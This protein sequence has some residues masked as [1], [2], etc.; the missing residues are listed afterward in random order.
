[1]AKRDLQLLILQ[2]AGAV[3]HPP[4]PYQPTT[5]RYLIR[6]SQIQ[7]TLIR[8][9]RPTACQRLMP[10]SGEPTP[11]CTSQGVDHHSQPQAIYL[12]VWSHAVWW[13]RQHGEVQIIC[14]NKHKA[15]NSVDT[16]RNHATTQDYV[17]LRHALTCGRKTLLPSC[18]KKL[19]SMSEFW[20]C[21]QNMCPH[22]TRYRPQQNRTTLA[23][24][25]TTSRESQMSM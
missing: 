1:M 11:A 19:L 12:V 16:K 24:G 14:D 3:A 5:A 20:K 18:L 2:Y 6:R 17:S 25:D 8:H 21:K 7:T 22:S 4:P 23:E 13:A 9:N 10:K 15:K